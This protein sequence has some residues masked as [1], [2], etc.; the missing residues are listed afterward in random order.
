MGWPGRNAWAFL[1]GESKHCIIFAIVLLD[2]VKH[3]QRIQ[4]SNNLLTLAIRASPD[5]H[6]LFYQYGNQKES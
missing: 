6:F 3:I 1:F 5:S 4:I 2:G